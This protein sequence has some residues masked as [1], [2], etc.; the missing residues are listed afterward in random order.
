MKIEFYSLD[1]VN[2]TELEFAVISAMYRGE[3]GLC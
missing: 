1:S 3:V 2:E